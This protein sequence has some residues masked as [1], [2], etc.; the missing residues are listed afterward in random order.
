[1]ADRRAAA[2][3][4]CYATARLAVV[5]AGTYVAFPAKVTL[6]GYVA[7]V[8]GAVVARV[9]SRFKSKN[10]RTLRRRQYNKDGQDGFVIWL[11]P[12]FGSE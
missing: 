11:D 7:V 5:V 10:Q 1:M 4:V 3:S 8:A 9:Y 12:A 6:M 2:A